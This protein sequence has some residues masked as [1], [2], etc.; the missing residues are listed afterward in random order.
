M[1]RHGR[2]WRRWQL[3]AGE[4]FY[5]EMSFV[6][7]RGD[8]ILN[9]LVEERSHDAAGSPYRARVLGTRDPKAN[10]ALGT[11]NSLEA[12]LDSLLDQLLEGG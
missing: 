6:Y 5:R 1:I 2:D 10:A 12:A 8:H 9:I 3:E 7:R 11:G 4:D